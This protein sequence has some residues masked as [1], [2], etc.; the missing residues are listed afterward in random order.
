M[1]NTDYKKLTEFL[2]TRHA[3][4]MKLGLENI[5]KLLNLLDNPQNNFSSVHITGTNGKGSTVAI[6]ESIL[7]EAG[8]RCGRFTSPHLVDMRE[9]INF[10]GKAI[11]EN[12]V[13]HLLDRLKN[14]IES[15][16]TSFFEIL[17]AMSFLFFK[18]KECEI[19]VLE[20]GLGGRLDA[21]ST[22]NPLLTIITDIGFDHTKT[23]GKTLKSISFEKAGI[24]KTGVPCI[25]GVKNGWV[26]TYLYKY[27]E[28]KNVPLTFVSDAVRLSNLELSDKGT[29]FKAETPGSDYS[30]LYL[31]LT[32]EHQ[33]HNAAAALLAVDVLQKQNWKIDDEAVRKGLK[34]VLWPGR[35]QVLQEKPTL[36]IDAAH[37]LMGMK[38]FVKSLKLFDYD[39]LILLFGVLRDKD[40]R[41]MLNLIA[42]LCSRIILTEPEISRALDPKEIEVLP[43]TR[44]WNIQ[45]IKDIDQA[46]S[47]AVHSA[48]PDDLVCAAGSIYFIGKILADWNKK[49][50]INIE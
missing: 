40:Y 19:A 21:T 14:F 39:K 41:A 7:R 15:T 35:L 24:W 22:V 13:V 16:G 26:K 6:L 37:N 8:Y 1:Q 33:V 11:S 34:N 38:A 9:R 30:G 3:K 17:T 44:S 32:G 12:E 23:L 28:Q 31:S 47:E 27:A 36:L 43:E 20:T 50:G 2:F 48:G 25:S 10:M 45:T 5:T 46:W 4:G 49:N 29:L 18:E 42:P